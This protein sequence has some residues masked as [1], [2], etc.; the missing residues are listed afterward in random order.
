M[1]HEFYHK[2]TIFVTEPLLSMCK[3]F[4][5]SQSSEIEHSELN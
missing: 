5:L 3:Y 1:L 2:K 4:V